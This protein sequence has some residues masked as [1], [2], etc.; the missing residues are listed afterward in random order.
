MPNKFASATATLL[1]TADSMIATG[2]IGTEISLKWPSPTR[3]GDLLHLESTVGAIT[4]S[5]RAP[6]AGA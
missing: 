4:P 2:V 3:P 5:A 6:T 1:A